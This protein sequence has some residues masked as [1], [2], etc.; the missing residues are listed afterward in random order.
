[1]KQVVAL[2]FAAIAVAGCIPEAEPETTPGPNGACN[3]DYVQSF[4]GQTLTDDLGNKM[5]RKAGAS[6]LRV[7]HK[8]G[9]ITMDYNADRLNIFH[10][11]A[12][13]IVRANCG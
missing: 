7:A 11:D 5:Q 6:V 3:A 2:A 12:K 13:V 8:D 10:D 4:V 1:M 9:M